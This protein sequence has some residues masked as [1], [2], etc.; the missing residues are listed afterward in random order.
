M[1]APKGTPLVQQTRVC[2]NGGYDASVGI[3]RDIFGFLRVYFGFW[4]SQNKAP[5]W[6]KFE[7]GYS[8]V[9]TGFPCLWKLLVDTKVSQDHGPFARLLE[10]ELRNVPNFTQP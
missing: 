5:Y 7:R 3:R 10:V 2:L 8:M 6:M 1:A 4:V 9:C